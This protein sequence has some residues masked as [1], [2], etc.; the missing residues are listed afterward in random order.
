MSHLNS[1]VPRN[2]A[3]ETQN[4]LV[5]KGLWGVDPRND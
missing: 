4:L 5:L 2:M 1:N 3:V